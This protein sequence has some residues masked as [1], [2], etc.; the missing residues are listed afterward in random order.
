MKKRRRVSALHI[1][2]RKR[3]KARKNRQSP[4]RAATP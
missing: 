2:Q 4:P 3:M 1:Q